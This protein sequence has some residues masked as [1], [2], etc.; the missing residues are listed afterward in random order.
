MTSGLFVVLDSGTKEGLGIDSQ[1]KSMCAKRL[2]LLSTSSQLARA[3][4]SGE[5]NR[6]HAGSLPKQDWKLPIPVFAD[7]FI[8][9]HNLLASLLP[10][11]MQ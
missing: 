8:E 3:G 11:E 4:V 5:L 9:A 1:P 2:D 10:K 6:P 7:P